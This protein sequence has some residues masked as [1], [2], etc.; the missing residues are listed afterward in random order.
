MSTEARE[1]PFR[2]VGLNYVSFYFEEFE[3]A[4]AFYTGVLGPPENADAEG[5]IY[6]WRMGSTWLTF[7][8]SVVGTH[9]GS[10]PRNGEFAIQVSSPAEVDELYRTFLAAG[11][12]NCMEPEDTEMYEPMRFCCVDDP[13]GIRVDIYCPI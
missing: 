6:G 5:K 11:A 3:E 9:R 12:R 4:I 2:I 13:F 7:F 8:P 10:N 1:T